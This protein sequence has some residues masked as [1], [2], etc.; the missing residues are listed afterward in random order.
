[1]KSG[2]TD[3]VP[4]GTVAEICIQWMNNF[5]QCVK[6]VKQQ[7]ACS[8]VGRWTLATQETLV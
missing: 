1:M 2:L 6:H 5:V 4:P 8:V 7:T 3:R